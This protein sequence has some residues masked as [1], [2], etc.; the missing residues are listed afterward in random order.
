MPHYWSLCTMIYDLSFQLMITGVDDRLVNEKVV[1]SLEIL[2][3]DQEMLATILQAFILHTSSS[4]S[5]VCVE[6][7]TGFGCIMENVTSKIT[8]E[9]CHKQFVSF[10]KSHKFCDQYE[11]QM[12]LLKTV[13]KTGP[14]ADPVFREEC[15]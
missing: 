15:K 13:A 5:S 3:T 10:H 11:L 2:S 7:V 8:L 1:P 9:H 12:A 4:C 6:T 14:Q